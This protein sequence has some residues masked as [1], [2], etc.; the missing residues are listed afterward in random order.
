MGSDAYGVS[1]GSS[2]IDYYGYCVPPRNIVFPHEASIIFGFD[3]DKIQKF[4]Q[5]Q[6]HHCIDN[7]TQK[8]YDFSVFNVVRY[9]KLC[10]DGNPNVLDSLF[11]PR[12]CIAVITPMA[13]HIRHNRKIFLSKKCYSKFKG[14]G[15][16]QMAKIKNGSNSSN[17]KRKADIETH[18]LDLK[19][20]YHIARLCQENEQILLEHDLDIEQNRELLKSIRRGE[21]DFQRLESWWI[22]KEKSLEKLYVESTLRHEPAYDEIK[23][24]LLQCLEMVFGSLDKAYKQDL[25]VDKMIVELDNVIQK[26]R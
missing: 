5:W 21:W 15:F 17:P 9:F 14:Y 8:E 16:S 11:A 1:S 24:L 18:G 6:Q 19:F 26:Y 22:E 3:D 10:M 23:A 12:R 4:E 25:S 7:S 13:E 2:D 20:G